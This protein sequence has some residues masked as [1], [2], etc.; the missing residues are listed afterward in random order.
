MT[1]SPPDERTPPDRAADAVR[2]SQGRSLAVLLVEDNV[3]NQLVA[4]RMLS[5]LGHR[6]TTVGNGALAVAAAEQGGFDLILMDVMMPVMDGIA[7]TRAIRALPGDRAAVRIVA[8]T[9]TAGGGNRSLCF[10]AGMDGYLSK[11]TRIHLLNAEIEGVTGQLNL[12]AS[13]PGVMAPMLPSTLPLFDSAL[14]AALAAE[15]GWLDVDAIFE[16]FVTETASR[17]TELRQSAEAGDA[18]AVGRHLHAMKSAAGA[19]GFMQFAELAGGLSA[20]RAQP[21][22]ARLRC[23]SDMMDAVFSAACRDAQAWRQR[24]QSADF[25]AGHDSGGLPK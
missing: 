2:T 16:A 4:E 13:A 1:H 18:A 21:G 9:A 25:D 5:Q 12:A 20:G 19:L 6:V 10:Q 23:E 17:L 3:T 24:R 22:V 11:P 15:I 14:P 7:A 8:L